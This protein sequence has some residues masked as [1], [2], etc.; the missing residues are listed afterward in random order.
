MSD[1]DGSDDGFPPS[2]Q[3][4][5]QSIS[6]NVVEWMSDDDEEFEDGLE[7]GEYEEYDDEEEEEQSWDAG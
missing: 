4:I 2:G 7:S 1:D 3:G 6:Q 5:R